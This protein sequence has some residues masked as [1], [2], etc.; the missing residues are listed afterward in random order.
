M[1][2]FLLDGFEALE[3]TTQTTFSTLMRTRI[4]ALK[5]H[6]TKSLGL[7]KH[8]LYD[9]SPMQALLPIGVIVCEI[10]RG[11]EAPLLGHKIPCDRQMITRRG[12]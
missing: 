2:S 7:V 8:T 12:S 3:Y 11:K 5:S 6:Q 9:Y 10:K 4:F 1:H